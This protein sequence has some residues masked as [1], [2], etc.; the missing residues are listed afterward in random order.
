LTEI[1]LPLHLLNSSWFRINKL[2][3]IHIIIL[4]L[5]ISAYEKL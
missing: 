1:V 2:L 5:W 3:I 4:P